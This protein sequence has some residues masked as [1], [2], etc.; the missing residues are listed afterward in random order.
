MEFF[1]RVLGLGLARAWGDVKTHKP[2]RCLLYYLDNEVFPTLLLG[3]S[4]EIT[5]LT[6]VIQ[7]IEPAD[8]IGSVT[9][10]LLCNEILCHIYLT[11]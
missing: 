5:E 8:E 11:F 4:H 2:A 3:R 1:V 10:D 6:S 7:V 9:T